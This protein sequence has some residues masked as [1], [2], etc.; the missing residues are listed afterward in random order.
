[1]CPQRYTYY[2]IKWHNHNEWGG[3]WEKANDGEEWGELTKCNPRTVVAK[4]SGRWWTQWK[5]QMAL[6][7]IDGKA[8]YL[9]CFVYA[10]ICKVPSQTILS[11]AVKRRLVSSNQ[12]E[13]SAVSVREWRHSKLESLLKRGMCRKLFWIHI[14]LWWSAEGN[15]TSTKTLPFTVGPHNR[16][17]IYRF[18]CKKCSYHLLGE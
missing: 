10:S 5:W 18:F 17:K 12:S 4:C 11:P 8:G 3:K 6:L 14:I 9:L 2:S 15:S 13:Y 7:C 16:R 1:M